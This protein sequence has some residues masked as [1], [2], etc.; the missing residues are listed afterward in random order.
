MEQEGVFEAVALF[1]GVTKTGEARPEKEEL[2]DQ[3]KTVKAARGTFTVRKGWLEKLEFLA[4]RGGSGRV[5]LGK[6]LDASCGVDELL[7]TREEGV[8]GGTDPDA[9]ITPCGTGRVSGPA[10]ASDVG[11]FVAGMNIGFHGV[12]KEP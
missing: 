9:K 5:A 11:L 8:A 12:E 4:A 6:L 3:I 10:G 7:F 2:W 1:W